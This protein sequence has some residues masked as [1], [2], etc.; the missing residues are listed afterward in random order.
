MEERKKEIEL[1]WVELHKGYNF[2]FSSWK[3][4][5]E[6][7][8]VLSLKG[9]EWRGDCEGNWKLVSLVNFGRNSF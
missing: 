4:L 5:E 2:I 6:F 3:S 8:R 9:V 1:E 7:G